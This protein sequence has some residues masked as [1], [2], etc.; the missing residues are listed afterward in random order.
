MSRKRDH[1]SIESCSYV[2]SAGWVSVGDTGSSDDNAVMCLPRLNR[3]IKFMVG[4]SSTKA[5]NKQEMN[6]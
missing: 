5:Q 1:K 6:D 3:R 2:S 4:T